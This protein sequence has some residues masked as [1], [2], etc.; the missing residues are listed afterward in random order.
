MV[1]LF[2]LIVC[3]AYSAPWWVFVIGGLLFLLEAK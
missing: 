2:A 1:A 3:I